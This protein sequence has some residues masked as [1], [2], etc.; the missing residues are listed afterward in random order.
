MTP[1]GQKM[2]AL[3]TERNLTLT[4]MAEDLHLSP[5]YLSA[6]EHGQRGKPSPGL[7]MQIL[8]YFN[9]IWDDAEDIKALAD[10]SHPK[11]TID[12]AGLSPLAT[13][14]ANRL[15]SRIAGLPETTLQTML[16]L[17]RQE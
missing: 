6:L 17:I 2:R 3:R 1:F 12:T 8:G 9:L 10:I 14:L 15:S 13:E 7:V 4:R 11:V 5:A 16:D